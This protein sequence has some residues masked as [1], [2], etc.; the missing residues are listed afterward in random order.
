MVQLAGERPACISI[1][2][3]PGRFVVSFHCSELILFLT[4]GSI[5]AGVMELAD[6]LDSK[7]SVFGRAGSTPAIG[8]ILRQRKKRTLY[9]S[10]TYLELC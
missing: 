7:S 3:I 8:T 6:V 9:L 1:P 4:F 2:V 5:F 10:S